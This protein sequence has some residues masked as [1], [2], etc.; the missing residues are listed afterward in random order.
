MLCYLEDFWVVF[1]SSEEELMIGFLKLPLASSSNERQ[2]LFRI[3]L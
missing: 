2:K 1:M 3:V